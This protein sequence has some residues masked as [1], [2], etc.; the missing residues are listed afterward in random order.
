MAPT[1]VDEPPPPE[2]GTEEVMA[3]VSPLAPVT[4]TV[5]GAKRGAWTSETLPVEQRK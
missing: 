5:L 1:L 2:T 4:V 3:E